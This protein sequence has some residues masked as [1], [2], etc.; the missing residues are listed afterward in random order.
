MGIHSFRAHSARTAERLIR[1]NPVHVAVVDLGLPM[2]D[3]C[4]R[5]DGPIAGE[6]AGTRILE[7]LSRLDAPP[8]TVV[9]Q[10]PRSSRDASRSLASALR[11]GAYAVV[12]RSAA[13]LEFMLEVLRRCMAKFY[14]GRWPGSLG[15]RS[16]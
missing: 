12:D 15:P 11:C 2:D 14:Q 16:I 8:P 1:D 10:A 3:P 4:D 6:E 9:V 13:D 7:L 5:A